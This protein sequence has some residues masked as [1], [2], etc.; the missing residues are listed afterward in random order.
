M[1]IVGTTTFCTSACVRSCSAGKGGVIFFQKVVAAAGAIHPSADLTTGWRT[2]ILGY[3]LTT[4]VMQVDL[5][6]TG[7]V[8]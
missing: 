5:T 8:N 7:V 1:G 3:A 6:N 4:S 2:S